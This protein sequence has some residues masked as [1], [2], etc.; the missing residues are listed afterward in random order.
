MTLSL[1]KLQGCQSSES[2]VEVVL[3]VGQSKLFLS[4]LLSN[5]LLGSQLNSTPLGQKTSWN[6]WLFPKIGLGWAPQIIHFNSPSILGGS[7]LPTSRLQVFQFFSL[8]KWI[9]LLTISLATMAST[10]ISASDAPVHSN[11]GRNGR[12]STSFPNVCW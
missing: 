10:Y 4:A 12:G 11:L 8:R 3:L 5:F 9:R 1:T 6:I 7:H 2:A